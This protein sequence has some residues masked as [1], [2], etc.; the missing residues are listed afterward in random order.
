M[1]QFAYEFAYKSYDS[2]TTDGIVRLGQNI[3]FNPIRNLFDYSLTDLSSQSIC[4]LTPAQYVMLPFRLLL[5]REY[6]LN[7][8]AGLLGLFVILISGPVIP[9]VNSINGFYSFGLSIMWTFIIFLMILVVCINYS[10]AMNDCSLGKS[11]ALDLWPMFTSLK[12]F[13][14]IAAIGAVVTKTSKN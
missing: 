10:Y 13:A 14:V 5:K 11:V 6:A 1:S 3:L 8:F 12:V 4:T 2:D 9:Y 7:I